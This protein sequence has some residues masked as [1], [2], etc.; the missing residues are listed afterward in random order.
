MLAV[1]RSA[2]ADC[3][4]TRLADIT[5]LD[6]IGISVFQAVR[7]LGRALSVHQGKGLTPDAA[8]VGALMEAV[9]SDHAERFDGERR[10]AAFAA[11]PSDERAPSLGDFAEDRAETPDA[12]EPIAWTP[13][14]R[15]RDGSRLWAPF[16]C[17]SLDYTY[18]ADERLDRSSN[19]LG[20]GVDLPAAI[21]TALLELLE[22]DAFWR[23]AN[24]DEAARA[25]TEIDGDT[26]PLPWWRILVRKLDGLGMDAR[27]W[28]ATPLIAAVVIVCEIVEPLGNGERR[29][30]VG[31]AC[32]LD[33]AAAVAAAVAEA[34]QS[35]LTTIAGVRDDILGPDPTVRPPGALGL[36][37]PLPPTVAPLDWRTAAAGEPL[38]D[39]DVI[40][41]ARALADAGHRD[42]AIVDLSRAGSP[43]RVVK[44]FAPGLAAFARS[45]SRSEWRR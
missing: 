17:V 42:A 43:V 6:R 22:R 41:L 33:F 14:R 16:D 12:G 19:G 23:W 5:G 45:P 32:R 37:F 24:L 15:L 31:A 35:R 21:S 30:S 2:A 29:R 44:A 28:S 38:A 4:V 25:E 11:L 34:A 9:E 8:R 27:L 13:A 36:A 3:G 20:A 18:R 39:A 26:L 1:A 7:P 10:T 40:G